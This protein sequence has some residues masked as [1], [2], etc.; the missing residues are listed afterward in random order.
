MD[1]K[2]HFQLQ[3]SA[4]MPTYS[5][6]KKLHLH[7]M[8][9]LITAG[10]I[11]SFLDGKVE[12]NVSASFKGIS[13]IDFSEENSLS[14]LANEK[15]QHHLEGCKASVVLVNETLE[16]VR[17]THITYVRVEDAYL[18]FCLVL[19][20]Y[21]NPAKKSA[22]IA[23]SA[24]IHPKAVIG[25]GVYIGPLVVIEA[26]AVI[27]NEAIVEARSYIGENVRLGERSLLHPNVTVYRECSIGSDC[28][29]HSGTV[30]GS[31]GFG[32]APRKD[33]TYVKIPQLGN[34]IIEEEVEVGSNCTIDRA[35]MG[36]TIIRKGV[37]LDNLIQIAHNVE[38]DRH[39]VIA[40]QTGIA[41]STYIGKHC[42]IAG[43]VGIV[44]HISIADR[45]QIGAQSGVNH[46]VKESGT[47]LTDSPAFALRDA[48]KSRVLYRKLPELNKRINDLERT[49]HKPESKD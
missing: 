12:G 44:G 16:A 4:I 15:Y 8:S 31:D 47:Q 3:H 36:S 1:G 11:A 20:R 30:I 19:N 33:G 41:G 25:E 32:H 2:I 24:V 42:I 39:T 22:G 45:T 6:E 13:K 38:I 46:S 7:P 18:A 14:F 34:V 27:G 49:I 40:A 48:F 43:Q 28:I 35:T 37:R 21:F 9:N 5:A 23:P 29:I 10:E 17:P 26:G